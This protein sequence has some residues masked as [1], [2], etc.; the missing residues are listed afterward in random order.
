MQEKFCIFLSDGP[1]YQHLAEER[2]WTLRNFKLGKKFF[3]EA[4]QNLKESVQTSEKT[5]QTLKKAKEDAAKIREEAE[6]DAAES[7]AE[8]ASKENALALKE[9]EGALDLM[10][11]RLD[12]RGVLTDEDA[13]KIDIA[14]W[15][16]ESEGDTY[17]TRMET[18]SSQ[19][20]SVSSEILASVRRGEGPSPMPKALEDYTN[21]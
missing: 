14:L 10:E 15:G 7:K 8:L 4:N 19:P 2:D 1:T 16:L 17:I 12:A 11:R 9:K 20:R 18:Y 5:N 13:T 21:S 6:E 3:T